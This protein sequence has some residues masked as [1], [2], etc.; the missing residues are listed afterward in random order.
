M[1][2]AKWRRGSILT[3]IGENSGSGVPVLTIAAG[4]G[5]KR[6]FISV[7]VHHPAYPGDARVT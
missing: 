6:V 4:D 1:H 5:A 7:S 2:P 3:E